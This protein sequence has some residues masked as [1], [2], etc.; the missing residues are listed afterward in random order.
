MR[1]DRARMTPSLAM[2]GRICETRDA[3][4]CSKSGQRGGNR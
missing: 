1:N 3:L 4:I 2:G